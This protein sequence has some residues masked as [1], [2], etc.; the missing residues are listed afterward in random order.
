[1]PSATIAVKANVD[2]AL[3][4]GFSEA[5]VRPRPETQMSAIVGALEGLGITVAIEDGL[6]VLAQGTTQMHTGKALRTLATKPEFK[7][8]F[9]Q[10]GS[11]PSQW[12]TEKKIEYLKTHSDEEFR[13]LL[14]APALESGVR[15]MD[16]NMSR[17]DYANLTRGEKIA[18]LREF[19]ADAARHIML[20]K[21]K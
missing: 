2:T 6:L 13:A 7:D 9:V 15:T 12:S 11:H 10:E 18:F 20:E 19:G 21:T 3:R 8:F 14:Q 16:P 1:M 5:S 4:K 17:K